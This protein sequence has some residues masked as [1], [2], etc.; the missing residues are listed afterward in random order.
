MAQDP[1]GVN[2]WS[3]RDLGVDL[4]TAE[5]SGLASNGNVEYI[6]DHSYP[7]IQLVDSNAVFSEG[8]TLNFLTT[9]N[10]WVIHDYGEAISVSAPHTAKQQANEQ[11]IKS[12]TM[13][14]ATTAEELAK[15]IAK[16]GWVSVEI[17]AGTKMLKRFLWIESKK[18]KFELAGYDSGAS[19]EKAYARLAKRAKDMGLPWEQ[20]APA[21]T[22]E[23][24][25][26]TTVE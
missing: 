6:C 14:Q 9:P 16:K 12:N 19:D 10:G 1:Q 8:Q 5:V 17:I 24:T 21:K 20:Q 23:E 7:F 4:S 15:L 2:I 11:V 22:T 13:D 3:Q 18:Y 26:P 25:D